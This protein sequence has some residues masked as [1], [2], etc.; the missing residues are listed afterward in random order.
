M[1]DSFDKTTAESNFWSESTLEYLLHLIM[2][3]S[4][5]LSEKFKAKYSLL[6][7]F[8]H[9]GFNFAVSD[10]FFAAGRIYSVD[11]NAFPG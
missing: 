2:Q 10:G 1:F 9:A 7:P 8:E 4:N 6:P 5:H 3:S 11:L